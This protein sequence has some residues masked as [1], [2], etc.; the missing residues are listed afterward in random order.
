MCFSGSKDFFKLHTSTLPVK[1]WQ[2]TKE[3]F[4]SW[5]TN[6]SLCEKPETIHHCFIDCCRAV[7]FY[8]L[9]ITLKKELEINPISIRFLDGTKDITLPYDFIFLVELHG[10]WRTRTTDRHAEPSRATKNIFQ[11]EIIQISEIY[12]RSS[13]A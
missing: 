2:K 12:G 11:E 5:D 1:E 9:L 13:E 3:F 6:C 10:F 8:I 7:F 4:V